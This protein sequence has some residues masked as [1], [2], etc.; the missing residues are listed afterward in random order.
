MLIETI[1]KALVLF[2][3]SVCVIGCGYTETLPQS[4]TEVDFVDDREGLRKPG[5][6]QITETFPT[7][8]RDLIL[9]ACR[10][11]LVMADFE[12]VASGSHGD[13]VLGQR[14]T[15][16]WAWAMGAGIYLNETPDGIQIKLIVNG[17]NAPKKIYARK[18]MEG[19]RMFIAVE[20]TDQS[21][22][23]D[24]LHGEGAGPTS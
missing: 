18:V 7:S 20:T 22:Q 12:I 16:A 23:Y 24:Q 13:P 5:Y 10:G 3:I 2:T 19:I 1:T 17:P 6:W 4:S 15:T 21:P 8:D 11:G 14:A 9:R